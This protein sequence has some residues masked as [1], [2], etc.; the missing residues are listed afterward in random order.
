M[1]KPQ[2][3]ET[4]KVEKMIHV[5]G[6]RKRAVARATIRAGKGVIRINSV[7]LDVMQP[8]YAKMIVQEAV[9]LAGDAAKG[10]DITIQATGG[11]VMGQAQAIALTIAKGL[12]QWTD[13]DELRKLYDFYDKNLLVAD[14]RQREPN[15]PGPSSARTSAQK[16]KR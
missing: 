3:K 8:R 14:S 10:V 16:S 4:P 7:P 5:S 1:S 11:G 2:K 9:E 15:K 13:S 6:K 12:V